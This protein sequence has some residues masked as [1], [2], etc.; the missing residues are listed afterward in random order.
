[1][2][3]PQH[4]AANAFVTGH[5]PTGGLGNCSLSNPRTPTLVD[6]FQSELSGPDMM[7]FTSSRLT[8]RAFT[9]H[10]R[11]VCSTAPACCACGLLRAVAVLARPIISSEVFLEWF[12]FRLLSCQETNPS[13][14][15]QQPALAY[16]THM[17]G[18]RRMPLNSIK[19][20]KAGSLFT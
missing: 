17:S 5:P 19:T 10:H 20:G 7:S 16:H 8:Q 18:R 2:Q 1:M 3:Q 4:A 6:A 13:P 11:T 9:Q 15:A 14:D 12:F